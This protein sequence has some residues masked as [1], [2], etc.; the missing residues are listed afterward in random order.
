[1]Q[2]NET[3]PGMVKKLE[4]GELDLYLLLAN[5]DNKLAYIYI[6]GP[7]TGSDIHHL[8]VGV[9]ELINLCLDENISIEKIIERLMYHRAE[10]SGITN[11][12]KI[13][14]SI[15]DFIAKA[16]KECYCDPR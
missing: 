5:R 3:L 4:I 2:I 8:I 9:T 15:L 13:V 1:M 16:L 11:D 7:R 10:T 6:A 12:K 14:S